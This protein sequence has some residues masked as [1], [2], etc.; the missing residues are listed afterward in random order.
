LYINLLLSAFGEE[1]GYFLVDE[2]NRFQ[3]AG[4]ARFARSRG[5]HLHDDPSKG[6]VGTISFFE[7]WMYELAAMEQGAML[8]NLALMAQA[9]GL[10]GFPHF[11]A[12]P[13]GWPEALGFRMEQIPMSRVMGVGLLTKFLMRLLGKDASVPSPVG[14]EVEDEVIIKPYC[15]P[16][17]RSMEEAVL[18]FVDHKFA[19]GEGVFCDGGRAT[20]W[21]DGAGIQ[22][23][24][25]KYSDGAIA[26]TIAYCQYIYDRYGRFLASCGPFRTILAYQAHHLDTGFYDR[27]YRPEVLTEAQ[28]RHPAHDAK[29][30]DAKSH[31]AMSG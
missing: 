7:S 31:D 24:I 29:S 8:Q 14:L 27:F 19:E 6:R 2:R 20:G 17:Y 11:T 28:R 10:G 22:R 16:Y 23:Q 9:L 5:G 3:P 4:I 26:A 25:P 21:R 15:P 13:F 12:H 30:H 1:A 18:A